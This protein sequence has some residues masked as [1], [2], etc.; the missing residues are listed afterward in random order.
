M[1][2]A[3]TVGADVLV[4]TRRDDVHAVAVAD[5]LAHR[6]VSSAVVEIDTVAGRGGLSW[7]PDGVGTVLDVHDRRVRVA[8]A[9]V[10]WWRRLNGAQ[11]LPPELDPAAHELVN[12]DSRASLLGLIA[13]EFTGR[14]VSDPEATRAAENK[15]VQLRA[16]RQ[17]GL[18][19]PD[20]LVSS[21]PAQVRRFCD[22]HDWR[23]VV[24]TVS[25]AGPRQPVMTG[26]HTPELVQDAAV[27]LSPAIY[28][29]LVPG[30]RHLRV[31]V[32]GDDVRTALLTTSALDWRYPLDAAVEAT[33][34][35]ALT[36]RRLHEVLDV[37][38][39]RMG[40]FDLKLGPDGEPVW[41]EL[42]PQGQFLWL[43]G[44]AGMNLQDAFADFLVRELG[45][46]RATRGVPAG[47]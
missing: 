45:E 5:A 21:D 43:D 27:R 9:A 38:G 33:E 29:E 35:D 32:F 22:A 18:R 17:A 37:L 10:A 41:L 2:D 36:T 6:G 30:E 26:A 8:D 16:A 44:L 12:R 47:T 14:Y 46:V 25:G 39:L 1:S 20:T 42:N 13:T 4:V 24:K 28:Q 19:V 7:S 23:V 3:A 11:Q 34:L 40:V 15:L 31:N